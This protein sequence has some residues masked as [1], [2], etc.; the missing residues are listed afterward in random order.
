MTILKHYGRFIH[1]SLADDFAMSKIEGEKLPKKVQI[2]HAKA[3]E[4]EKP[5]GNTKVFVVPDGI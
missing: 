2:G 3:L 1:S 4:I 5:R